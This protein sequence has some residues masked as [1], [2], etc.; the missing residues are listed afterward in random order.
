MFELVEYEVGNVV[1]IRVDVGK[2]G[3]Q[4]WQALWRR[5]EYGRGRRYT[6]GGEPRHLSTRDTNQIYSRMLNAVK[7]HLEISVSTKGNRQPPVCR[8]TRLQNNERLML[9]HHS[10]TSTSGYRLSS[11][12]RCLTGKTLHSHK[13]SSLLLHRAAV[14]SPI[15]YAGVQKQCN[16]HSH[17]HGWRFA[18]KAR[19]PQ[20]RPI[21]NSW[22]ITLEGFRP[23]VVG[24][25][26]NLRMLSS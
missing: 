22:A 13:C 26:S 14:W 24:C 11:L 5:R 9:L 16:S 18:E 19:A 20:R 12:A 25:T 21:G 15:S 4:C 23:Y 3:R 10:S 7:L 8:T 17:S 1:E 6:C 2:Y